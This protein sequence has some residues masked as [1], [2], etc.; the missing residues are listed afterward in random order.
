MKIGLTKNIKNLAFALVA[1]GGMI[2]IQNANAILSWPSPLTTNS[3]NVVGIAYGVTGSGQGND[4]F[5]FAVAQILLT[6]G[7][8]QSLTLPVDNTSTLFNTFATDY[9]GLVKTNSSTSGGANQ[10]IESGWDYVLAKYD[11]KNAGYILFSLGGQAANLP[12][13][14]ANFWTTDT[15]QYGISGWTAFDVDPGVDINTNSITPVPEPSTIVAG[16]LLLLPFGVGAIRS[17]RRDRKA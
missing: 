9:N 11:G 10:Q 13:F 1:V 8:N 16:A 4:D 3:P 5:K 6:M 15:E 17:L 14:P 7:A 2:S 12:Q